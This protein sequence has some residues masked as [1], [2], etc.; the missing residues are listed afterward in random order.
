MYPDPQYF[1]RKINIHAGKGVLIRDSI[2][3][4]KFPPLFPI[5]F[6]LLAVAGSPALRAQDQPL[7]P[8]EDWLEYYYQNPTPDRFVEEVKNWASDGTLDNENARPALIAFLSQVMRANR[9]QIAGWYESLKGL[10][11]SQMQV[12]HTAMLYARVSEADE[13]M[14]KT[15]GKQYDDQKI[16]T[17]KILEM[18]L[19][20]ETTIDMLW[21]FFYATGSEHAI[22]RIVLC[23]R[24]ED[25][26][27]RPDGVD[28]PEGYAA[29]YKMLPFF[30]HDSLLAN[31][32]RHPRLVEILKTL[33][34]K[35][36]ELVPAEK[37]GVYDVLSALDPENVPPVDREAKAA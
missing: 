23:F 29:L 28:V 3:L 30:A 16:E 9:D 34:E 4:M 22:R 8:E 27:E 17:A 37:E 32:E 13:I 15:F 31:A 18:P 12:L 10:S 19:D 5:F 24:F 25:A 6:C 35:P 20:K 33:L 36:E 2:A 7:Q 1:K 11:P 14:S 26:P 21:G